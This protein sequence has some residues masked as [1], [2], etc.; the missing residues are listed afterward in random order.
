EA[1]SAARCR[2]LFGGTV[3]A[4][5]RVDTAAGS[6]VVRMHGRRGSEL[7]ADRAREAALHRAAAAVGVAPAVR[8]ADEAHRFMIMDFVRGPVWLARDFSRADRLRGLCESLSALHGAPVPAVAP[9]DPAA[10]PAGRAARVP[11]AEPREAE[12]VGRLLKKAGA[13]LRGCRSGEREPVLVHNALHHANL[14]GEK[15]PMLI[16]WEYAAVADPLYDL[17]CVLE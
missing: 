17:G 13:A 2:R 15:A 8:Y 11:E 16:D 1:G 12:P 7:G 3:N 6:F 10:V 14:I 9:F 4:S 5:F